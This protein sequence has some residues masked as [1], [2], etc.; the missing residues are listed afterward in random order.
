MTFTAC[1]E[2]LN[3]GGDVWQY[4]I[5]ILSKTLHDLRSTGRHLLGLAFKAS[6]NS[7]LCTALTKQKITIISYAQ[8]TTALQPYVFLT[9]IHQ[10]MV[11]SANYCQGQLQTPHSLSVITSHVHAK[12]FLSLII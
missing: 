2:S 5:H 11:T 10:L 8:N 3:P 6:L 12:M 9:G 4:N 1:V 7:N